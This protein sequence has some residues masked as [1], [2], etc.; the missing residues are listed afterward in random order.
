M[1]LAYL[2]TI[3]PKTSHSF[4]RREI[5][6]LERRGHEVYR[7][8][9]REP[10]EPLVNRED[11]DESERTLYCVSQGGIA[12]L[13][14]IWLIEALR[15]PIR[16]FATIVSALGMS[17]R[18][19][20]GLLRHLAYVVE[21]AFLRAWL[22]QHP[23][24]HVH[25]H[26]GTNPAAVARL[27]WQLGGPPYSFTI[28]GPD[29]WDAPIGLSLGDKIRDARF[30]A[31]ISWY[32]AAQVSRW[33]RSEDAQKVHVIRCAPPAD[34]CMNVT[35]I[36]S[37][38]RTLLFVGRLSPQKAPLLLI[39]AAILL[40]ERGLDYRLE[41]VGDGELRAEIERRIRRARLEDRIVLTGWMEEQS[42]FQRMRDARCLVLP[43]LAE[44]LPVVIM[45]AFSLHRPVIST[46]VGGIPEL[47]EP[48]ASGWLVPCG[49]LESLANA[50][51]SAL[52]ATTTELDAMGARGAMTVLVRHDLERE[53]DRLDQAFEIG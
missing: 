1:K 39:D 12:K 20:R 28:H 26:F 47:V 5:Q 15:R 17:R 52:E 33:V 51:R 8:S 9:I 21:A 7:I 23:V 31:V 6:A 34:L 16:M 25:A 22:R 30:V 48:G 24:D 4:I 46:H 35:A 10:S 18:S 36:P 37:S 19:E 14:G 32:S 45:E 50:M 40:A 53:I 42:V 38:S 3:Y 49:D 43:S 44:G 2:T 29:E 41:L 11:R 27:L 13:L